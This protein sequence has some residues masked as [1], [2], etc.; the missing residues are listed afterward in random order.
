M[1]GRGWKGF[2]VCVCGVVWGRIWGFL[3]GVRPWVRLRSHAFTFDSL[4]HL[5]FV[6]KVTWLVEGS[7]CMQLN[8]MCN[9]LI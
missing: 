5:Y 3:E 6:S 4:L 9:L 8:H 2:R 1:R 7:L